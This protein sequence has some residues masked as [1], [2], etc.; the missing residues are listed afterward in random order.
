MSDSIRE[1]FYSALRTEDPY[2]GLRIAVRAELDRGASKKDLLDVLKT[3]RSELIAE[4]RDDLE[5][6]VFEVMHDIVGFTGPHMQL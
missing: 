5:Y 1:S 2:V 6:T 3:M 4:G